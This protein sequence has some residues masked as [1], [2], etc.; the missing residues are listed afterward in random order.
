MA[1]NLERDTIGD[2]LISDKMAQMFVCSQVAPVLLQ[3]LCQVGRIGV[4]VTGDDPVCLSA[5]AD[6]L[7]IQGYDRFSAGRCRYG[8]CDTSEPRKSGTVDSA[9]PADLPSCND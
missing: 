7:P 3:E 9:G 2:I 4:S 8:I 6:F 1:C 5:Q